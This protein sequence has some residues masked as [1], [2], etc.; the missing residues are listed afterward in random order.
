MAFVSCLELL[1]SL[2]RSMYQ[3]SLRNRFFPVY[4]YTVAVITLQLKSLAMR[5]RKAVTTRDYT[6]TGKIKHLSLLIVE[7][8]SYRE[9][10]ISF[11]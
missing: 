6:K 11:R 4:I 10:V 3:H 2:Y 9:R 7:N 1:V 5:A 8:D